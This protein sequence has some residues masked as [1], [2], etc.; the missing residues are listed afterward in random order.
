MQRMPRQNILQCRQRE[1]LYRLPIKNS[2]SNNNLTLVELQLPKRSKRKEIFQYRI[3]RLCNKTQY[4][5]I[6]PVERISVFYY[7]ALVL[8]V[9]P[10]TFVLN[11]SKSAVGVISMKQK[12]KMGTARHSTATIDTS[13]AIFMFIL[14]RTK[15]IKLWSG[16]QPTTAIH[17]IMCIQASKLRS[18]IDIPSAI[19]ARTRPCNSEP[20][21]PRLPMRRRGH[22]QRHWYLNR[23][24]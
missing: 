20:N 24:H 4:W 16:R 23:R 10:S 13:F 1:S 12:Q 14:Y 22:Y 2:S 8:V 7:S 15:H 5:L 17:S 21:M 18:S 11:R 3:S 9:V 19:H 6:W